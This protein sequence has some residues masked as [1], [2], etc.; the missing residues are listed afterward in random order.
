[1]SKHIRTQPVHDT[2]LPSLDQTTTECKQAYQISYGW[3]N[4]TSQAPPLHRSLVGRSSE[5]H[6]QSGTLLLVT[7]ITAFATI[8]KTRHVD[9]DS[10]QAAR[11]GHPEA[12][13]SL[14]SVVVLACYCEPHAHTLFDT[15]EWHHKRC[16]QN[17]LGP[18]SRQRNARLRACFCEEARCALGAEEELIAGR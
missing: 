14:A 2:T 4:A 10:K 11:H 13:R 12:R 8:Y 16:R 1:M 17:T 3:D 5:I 15:H 18:L 6:N 7:C 9:S